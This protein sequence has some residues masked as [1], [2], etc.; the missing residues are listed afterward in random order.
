MGKL[1]ASMADIA[2]VT[3]DNPRGEDPAVIRAAIADAD[4]KLRLSPGRADAIAVAL[5]EANDDDVIL[6]A[7]KGHEAYQ[8]INGQRVPFSDEKTALA[9]LAKR[10]GR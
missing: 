8:E 1:A 4:E 5:S 9:C 10:A 3:D 7:G 2:F 6:I